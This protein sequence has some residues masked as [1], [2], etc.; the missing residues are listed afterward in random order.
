MLN[1]LWV[2]LRELFARTMS[3]TALLELRRV[4]VVVRRQP[5][6]VCRPPRRRTFDH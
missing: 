1:C 4:P 3:V 5:R 6:V 2:T